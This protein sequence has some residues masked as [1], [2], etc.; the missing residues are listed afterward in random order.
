[1]FTFLIRMRQEKINKKINES[2][3]YYRKQHIDAVLLSFSTLKNNPGMEIQPD[4]DGEPS[5]I[6]VAEF[7]IHHFKNNELDSFNNADLVD[8]IDTIESMVGLM[9]NPNYSE[10]LSRLINDIKLPISDETIKTLELLHEDGEAIHISGADHIKIE[11]MLDFV[12]AFKSVRKQ[13]PGKFQ[14]IY[15]LMSEIVTLFK[16]NKLGRRIQFLKFI[17]RFCEY[18]NIL[19][20]QI[21]DEYINSN[22]ENYYDPDLLKKIEKVFYNKVKD[23]KYSKGDLFPPEAKLRYEKSIVDMEKNSKK[24]P[25]T[26]SLI[27]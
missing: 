6:R 17:Y 13:K 23:G 1:M 16:K 4:K 19:G 2:L 8:L 25:T 3:T 27:K 14:I 5:T 12:N 9:K 20:Y 22:D 10:D 18:F 24:Y 26:F 7:L 15:P 21:T 11:S